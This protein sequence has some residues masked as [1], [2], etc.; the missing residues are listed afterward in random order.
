[1][2]I[3]NTKAGRRELSQRGKHTRSELNRVRL[4]LYHALNRRDKLSGETEANEELITQLQAQE[5][6]LA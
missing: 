1:M 3:T 6:E 5:R 4:R 2:T